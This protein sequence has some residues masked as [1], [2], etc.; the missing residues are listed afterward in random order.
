MSRQAVRFPAL[1]ADLVNSVLHGPGTTSALLRQVVAA[2]AGALG[3]AR[4][5]PASLP[6]ELA[7]YV[8]RLAQQPGTVGGSDIAA[9]R[10]AGYSEEEIF[11]L[12]VSVALGASLARLER[13]LAALQEAET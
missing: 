10:L 6:A 4:R 3:G 2:R 11:E 12:T 9:L 13:G 8:D 1:I 7:P 5:E